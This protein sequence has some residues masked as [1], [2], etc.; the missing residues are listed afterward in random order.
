MHK[1]LF[2]LKF[3]FAELSRFQL[4]AKINYFTMSW[5][6]VSIYNFI[7]SERVLDAWIF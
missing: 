6:L 7:S 3:S 2:R 5:G 4:E 1:K